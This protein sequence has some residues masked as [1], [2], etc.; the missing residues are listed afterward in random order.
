MSYAYDAAV[1]S[2]A[3]EQ[4]RK[5][6]IVIASL[7]AAFG[8][9]VFGGKINIICSGT[10]G[11]PNAAITVSVEAVGQVYNQ[12]HDFVCL[13]RTMTPTCPSTWT[14]AYTTGASSGSTLSCTTDQVLFSRS[15]FG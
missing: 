5:M 3:P 14:G 1:G 8:L 10:R 15:S 4:P 6:M 9:A 13:G 12:A 11:M 2:Q 7:R